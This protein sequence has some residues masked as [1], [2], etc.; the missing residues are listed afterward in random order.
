MKALLLT[1]G[2]SE[3]GFGHITRC[4]SIYQAFEEQ[5]VDPLMIVKGDRSIE[6]LLRDFNFLLSDWMEEGTLENLLKNT[7]IVFIDSYLAPYEVYSFVSKRV[8]ICA[9][10]DDFMRLDYPEGIVVN[11]NIYATEID[12]PRRKHITYLLGTK[13]LPLRKP[14]WDVPNK[15]IRNKVEEVLITFGGSDMRNITPAVLRA[16]RDEFPKL[17]KTVVIGK[18]FRNVDEIRETMDDRTELVFYP[19]AEKIKEL[20]LRADIAISGGGQTLYELAR[21]GVPTVAVAV[22]E[23][24]LM[25]IY[26]FHNV[27]FIEYAGWWED[28]NLF[29]NLISCLCYLLDTSKRSEKMSLGRKIVDGLGSLRIVERVSSYEGR[30]TE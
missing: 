22:S 17:R 23:N 4:L 25:N 18:G 21:V 13:Y 2:G 16:V 19:D 7:D 1:E 20:M 3:I 10:Y 15:E 14:F 28:E 27:G 12:Y 11:G 8:K 30:Y 5:G 24:Q 29:N 6:R 26:S 9:Y